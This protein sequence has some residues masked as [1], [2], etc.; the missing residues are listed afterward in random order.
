[1]TTLKKT[2]TGPE[3]LFH[4][5]SVQGKVVRKHEPRRGGWKWQRGGVEHPLSG[6]Q[7]N[8]GHFS[9]KKVGV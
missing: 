7:W 2:A 1:M 4:V 9:V 3:H 8:R 5:G 6:S